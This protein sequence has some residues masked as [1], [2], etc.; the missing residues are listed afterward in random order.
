MVNSL[1]LSAVYIHGV[2]T[3]H[4]VR[5]KLTVVPYPSLLIFSKVWKQ[6]S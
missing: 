1:S 6:K 4:F 2:F 5:Q 3:I